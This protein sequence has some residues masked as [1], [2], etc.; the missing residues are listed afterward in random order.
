MDFAKYPEWEP[1]SIKSVEPVDKDKSN[2]EAGDKMNVKLTG[3]EFT[4]T[5]LVRS[6]TALHVVVYANEML[7]RRT[8]DSS[9][10]GG[11]ACHIFSQE[12]MLFDGSRAKQIQVA[13]HSSMK[14]TSLVS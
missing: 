11:E 6:S 1:R 5:V 2:I 7:R 14:R 13:L 8:Q 9:S 3:M 10:C 4:S 12:T